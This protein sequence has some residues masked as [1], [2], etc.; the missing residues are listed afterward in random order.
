M[1]IGITILHANKKI[2]SIREVTGPD[3]DGNIYL[4]EG[5]L[6]IEKQ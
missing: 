5:G 1:F 6:G 4:Q 2:S 3:A